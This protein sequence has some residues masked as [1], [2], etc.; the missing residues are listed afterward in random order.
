MKFDQKENLDIIFETLFTP[1][2]TRVQ[3]VV[4]IH[5][6]MIEKNMISSEKDIINDHIAF[7][8]LGV[9]N[10]GIASLEKIFLHYGYEKKDHYYFEQKKLDAYWYSPPQSKYPR[11]F[12]SELRVK[13]L[14]EQTQSIIWNYTKDITVDPIDE[15]D[16]DDAE[17]VGAFFE[18]PLWKLPT[19]ADYE[20]LQQQSEYAAWVIYN[21]YYLNH[22]TISIHELPEPYKK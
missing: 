16:L 4:K 22:Y 5:K 9:P 11:I 8:S 10:L 17:S 1:Y 6:A 20:S 15:L 7:R 21:S 13:D 3:D 2:K 14:P 12:I 18:N 19:L